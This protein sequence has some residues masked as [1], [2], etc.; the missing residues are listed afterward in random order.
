MALPSLGAGCSDDAT[1]LMASGGGSGAGAAGADATGGSNAGGANT[2]GS[3]AGGSSAGGSNAGGANAGGSNNSGGSN[4]GGSNSG[5]SN[6]GGSNSGG[7]N[8][9]G[10]NAGGSGTGS[11][12]EQYTPNQAKWDT[13]ATKP[14]EGGNKTHDPDGVSWIKPADWAAA[15]WDGTIYNPS[16]MSPQ[17]FVKAMCPS[18]DRVRGI[19]EV[20]YKA[21]PFADNA[22]PTKAEVDEWHRIAINHVRALVGYTSEDRKVKK[23]HCM[24]A[25]ALW[26]D[27]RKF[28]TMWDTKYPGTNGSAAGPCQGSSNAHCGATFLPSPEEQA[29][30]LPEGHPSCT[31]EAGSEG[32]FSGPKSNIPWSIKW[33]RGFCNTLMAEGY[34]GGHVG[35]WFHRERFGFSFWDDDPANNNNNAV[36]RAKWTGK[37]MPNLYCNPADAGC[38]PEKTGPGSAP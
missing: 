13:F 2:G 37:S 24:F 23:D 34:W 19:R 26:G 32:V 1:V 17:D 8:A 33:S 28:T 35:P 20:F 22:N 16:K 5:G 12:L 6:S 4:S 11:D 18:V 31:T 14:V 10:S 29:P 21:K 36:L 25:R 30:Y 3:H 27:E 7:S 15:E 9:G 38:D